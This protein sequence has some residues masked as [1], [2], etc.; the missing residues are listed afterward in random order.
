MRSFALILLFAVPA[1]AAPVPK[2]LKRTDAARMIGMWVAVYEATGG[3]DLTN[4]Q[5][6]LF[7]PGRLYIGGDGIPERKG[8]RFEMELPRDGQPSRIVMRRG[9][10]LVCTGLYKFEDDNLYIVY[11]SGTEC[12]K[13]FTPAGPRSIVIL[14][15]VPEAKK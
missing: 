8:T 9:P 11:V 10:T 4:D 13:D 6:W 1:L 3:H 15:R 7:E 5:L 2:E 12:P 14:K